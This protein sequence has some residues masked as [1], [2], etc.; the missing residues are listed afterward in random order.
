[1]KKLIDAI[2]NVFNTL[3]TIT[4]IL[5]IASAT[6]LLVASKY[7]KSEKQKTT[8]AQVHLFV[9]NRT[10]L[11]DKILVKI[12]INNSEVF[13]DSLSGSQTKLIN[14]PLKKDSNSLSMAFNNH[15]LSAD[16]VK[17][18]SNWNEYALCFVIDDRIKAGEVVLN[19][20]YNFYPHRAPK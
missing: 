7:S 6:Y 2:T 3:S 18:Q 20:S 12:E 5:I 14:I 16:T 4:I 1:M 17:A 11:D 8:H 15:T 10:R 9:E 13:N 19:A